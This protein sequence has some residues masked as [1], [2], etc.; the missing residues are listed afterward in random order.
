MLDIES[1]KQR[2]GNCNKNVSNACFAFMALRYCK[3]LFPNGLNMIELYLSQSDVSH[4]KKS[5]KTHS[6]KLR[7]YLIF[8]L[9]TCVTFVDNTFGHAD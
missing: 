8:R 6:W 4:V 7:I 9:I 2:L 1:C 5:L 3:F